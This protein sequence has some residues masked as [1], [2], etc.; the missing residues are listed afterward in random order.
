MAMQSRGWQSRDRVPAEHPE[1]QPGISG[2]DFP[3]HCG[4]AIIWGLPPRRD[5]SLAQTPPLPHS[6]LDPLAV[7]VMGR[8]GSAGTAPP[9]SFL[10][11][12][13]GPRDPR[14]DP[15][16]RLGDASDDSS[17]RSSRGFATAGSYF[18]GISLCST[19]AGFTRNRLLR[20]PELPHRLVPSPR[21][22]RREGAR[23]GGPVWQP[24]PQ[25]S[26][27]SRPG[28]AAAAFCQISR[29]LLLLSGFPSPCP[30][31]DSLVF[32]D[33]S[34]IGSVSQRWHQA[35]ASKSSFTNSAE[36]LGEEPCPAHAGGHLPYGSLSIFSAFQY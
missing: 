13:T 18:R 21:G 20:W 22:T 32:L 15:R 11:W 4:S 14:R 30:L 25:P 5:A 7:P 34:C 16:H 29:S 36:T 31:P 26:A 10:H 12:E 9:R 8:Q 24:Q 1:A 2:V 3:K 6:M 33:A 19:S 17:I 35:Q 28:P 27:R 23:A